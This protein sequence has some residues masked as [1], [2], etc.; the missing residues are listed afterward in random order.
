MF[1][2]HGTQPSLCLQ[3]RDLQ[4]RTNALSPLHDDYQQDI[5]GTVSILG[6]VETENEYN[7][8][9]EFTVT[10]QVLGESVNWPIC[11]PVIGL[12]QLL[13]P[14]YFDAGGTIGS[15]YQSDLLGTF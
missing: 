8:I 13:P 1:L 15:T 10:I 11:H 4:F 5:F 6:D 9:G 14:S 2:L 3:K 7:N 12:W